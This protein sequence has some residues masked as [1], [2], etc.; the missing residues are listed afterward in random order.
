MQLLGLSNKKALSNVQ[1][2]SPKD[3]LNLQ[4]EE[5]LVLLDTRSPGE[6]EQGHI[7]GAR[8]LPLFT[9]AERKI[10]GTTYK[11]VDPRK[12]LLEGLDIVGS[13]MRWL[14]EEAERLSSASFDGAKPCVGVYCWRGG[15]RSGSVAW[16]LETAGFEVIRLDGGYKAYRQ[17]ARD[18][19]TSNPW[20]LLVVDGPTGSGKTIFL[21]AL[22]A[23]GAQVVDLE[24]IANHK[25]SAFGLAPGATQPSGEHAEN[26]I[27]ATLSGFDVS[28]P[29]WVENESRNIGKVFLPTVFVDALA[30]GHRVELHV[31]TEDRIDHIVEQ[32]GAYKHEVLAD[33]FHHLRKRLGGKSTQDAIAA[34]DAGDL[35]TAA[36]IALL[37]Y[38]KAYAHYSQRQGHPT[39]E[40][41]EV[42]IADLDA[43]AQ[44]LAARR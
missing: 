30:K 8:S 14:V 19:L 35:R 26:M 11:Q 39:S 28:R 42:R 13:K 12:A 7:V 29:V 27:F 9:D 33:T 31:P 17:H 24:A 22:Q 44:R 3:F 2:V 41:H 21:N 1:L 25:G 37:Y 32:Y 4:R 38:D 40:R 34:I 23:Y 18:V 16:L 10:V 43:L 5:G 20:S 15:A 6:F 36:S